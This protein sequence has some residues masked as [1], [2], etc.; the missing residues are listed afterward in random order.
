M[1]HQRNLL[2]AVLLQAQAAWQHI[3]QETTAAALCN[4]H[5]GTL[6]QESA[7]KLVAA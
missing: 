7:P 3:L 4:R 5:W 6:Q 2:L 1:Q